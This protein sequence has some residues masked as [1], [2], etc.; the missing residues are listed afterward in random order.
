MQ[1]FRILRVLTACLLIL[2]TLSFP[3]DLHTG[4]LSRVATAQESQTQQ[5]RLVESIDF[6]GNR[7]FSDDNLLYYVQT[8]A[9]DPFSQTQVERDLQALLALTAFDKTATRVLTE[10]GVRGGVNVI[11]ELQELPIIRDLQ[12]EGLKAVQES[13]VLK[14]FRE[15]KVGISKESPFDPV[16][17][18]RGTRILRELLSAR[19]F[20]NAKVTVNAEEVSAT[21]TAVTFNI[22]QGER[23]RLVE[24][25]FDGNTVFKD[26]ELRS[27]LKLTKETGLFNLSRFQGTDI[28]DRQKLEYD[29][30]KNLLP[31]MQSKGYLQARIGEPQIEGL[32][33]R[34]T[35]FFLPLPFLSSKDDALRVTVP[36]IEGKLFRVG[37]VKITG[38]SIFSEDSIRGAIGLNK[39]DVVDGKRL[40]DFLYETGLKTEYGKQGFIEY[41]PDVNPEY[42]DNPTNPAEGIVDYTIAI[43]EGRQFTLRRLEFTGNTFTR[44]NVLR[45]EFLI[46]EGDVY[47]EQFFE[48]SVQKLNQTGYFDPIDKDKDK[49]IRTIPEEGFVDAV[50]KVRE[51]GRQQISFNGGVS[52]ISGSFFGLNYSTNNLFGRGEVLAVDFGLGNRQRSINLSFTEPYF[53]DRPISLGFSVFAYDRKFFGEGS[54]LS[55]NL[56]VQQS[57][58]NPLGTLTTDD[59]NLFTQVT[60]GASVFASAPLDEFYRKRRFTRF[61]RVGL[62]YQFSATSIKDPPVNQDPNQQNRIPVI[63]RQPNIITSR[64][65]PTFVYDS[66]NYSG[67]GIDPVSG[68]QLTVS[69]GLAGLGGDVRTYSPTAQYIKFLPVRRKRS[70]NPEVFGFRLLA[71]TVGSFATT[72]AIRNNPSLSFVGG[73]PIFERFF[74]G[75]EFTIRGYNTRSVGPIA[76]TRSFVTSRNVR[77]TTDGF[78]RDLATLPSV[79]DLDPRI[80]AQLAQLGT[81]TGAGGSNSALTGQS[82]QFVGGD[83]QLLGN[84]EYRVPIFGPASIAA[85]ADIGTAFNLRDSGVQSINS[86]FRPDQELLGSTNLSV[87]ALTNGGRIYQP[88]AFGGFFVDGTGNVLTQV[89]YR[90]LAQPGVNSEIA[91]FSVLG[92]QQV[93]LRGDVQ[94]NTQVDIGNSA[95]SKFSNYRAS[96]GLELRVQIPVVNAPFRLIYA[97]NP[98]AQRFANVGGLT[99]PLNEQRSVFRFSVGRTF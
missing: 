70:A 69:L 92:Y 49:E 88:S 76:P 46:N 91:P 84:F 11:F 78:S 34:R 40:R 56:D 36:V 51:R 41:N 29:V 82:F 93:F 20:P 6:Q 85:F 63:F 65:T 2:V 68:S 81:F 1:S 94:T 4:A 26:G 25:D 33:N 22:E 98:N 61:S 77:V 74:L 62:S 30:R 57:L 95:L 8:R 3:F 12:F 39:G 18:N 54:A 21:S 83:T 97:Y 37:D 45:R 86:E 96:V 48:Y 28:L 66:R 99:L 13:D 43:D 50:V 17:A 15:G 7:R 55:Q 90:S 24:L 5:Q 60:Y 44:D 23:S 67:N 35:G 52:G 42:K 53:R 58:L 38:N 72:S 47:N 16:K 27:Q 73:V 14:A 10:D 87:L 32:G 75:D 89:Q 80:V 59:R 79:P 31:Y 9:G 19:G 64:I 71:G